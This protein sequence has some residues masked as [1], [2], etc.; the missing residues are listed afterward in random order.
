MRCILSS[1]V[2]T[3]RNCSADGQHWQERQSKLQ[4]VIEQTTHSTRSVIEELGRDP[5]NRL[6]LQGKPSVMA[7]LALL[8]DLASLVRDETT[9][10]KGALFGVVKPWIEPTLALLSYYARDHG[11][12][13]LFIIKFKRESNGIFI[14]LQRLRKLFSIS[15]YR[16]LTV[17]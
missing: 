8:A 6:L 15:I 14:I 13:I 4:S 9:A 1:T 11:I 17:S 2:L 7:T 16:C 3:W 5:S 10:S 12:K